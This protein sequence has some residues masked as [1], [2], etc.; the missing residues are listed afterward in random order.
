MKPVINSVNRQPRPFPKLMVSKN[1][2]EKI[3]VAIS[4]NDGSLQGTIISGEKPSSSVRWLKDAFQDFEGSI[5]L[6]ND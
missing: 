3:L 6:S 5:T 4:N 1:N 2:P